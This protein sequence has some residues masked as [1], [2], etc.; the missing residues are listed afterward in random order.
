MTIKTMAN[1]NK[2]FPIHT[3]YSQS[4]LYVTPYPVT[5]AFSLTM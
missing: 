4:A 1:Q 3:D 2:A 5:Q